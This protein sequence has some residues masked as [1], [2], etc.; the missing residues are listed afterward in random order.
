MT[1]I[2]KIYTLF[3]LDVPKL[4]IETLDTLALIE[5]KQS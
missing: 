3:D 2:S 5:G 1:V 4:K